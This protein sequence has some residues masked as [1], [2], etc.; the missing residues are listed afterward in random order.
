[1]AN[2]NI[3]V[4]F[5]YHKRTG[6][7]YHSIHHGHHR[8]DWENRPLPFKVYTSLS[9]ILLPKE[10]DPTS[11]TAL[12]AIEADGQATPGAHLPNLPTLARVLFLGNG[13][14]RT[15]R[16]GDQVFS[17]RTSSCTGAL[18]HIELY[19]ACRDLPGLSAGLYHYGAHDHAL[20]RLREGD[21]REI[22]LRATGKEP[23]I[24]HAPVVVI[25][26][27]TFW[28]NSW[29]YQ[30]R[31][32]RHAFWDDGVILANLLAADAAFNLP[33]SVVGG[34]ADDAINELL[35]INTDK[36]VAVSLVAIG[37][38]EA[39]VPPAQR[40]TPLDLPTT[41][42]SPREVDYPL[43]REIHAASSLAEA[44][45]VAW[46][47]KPPSPSVPA[48]TGR[49][50]QLTPSEEGK[51]PVEPL[52]RVILRRGSTR[53]FSPA[54]ISL[55]LLSDM[56]TA[57]SRGVP[58]DFLEPFGASLNDWYL[59]VNGVDGL[60]SGSYFFRREERAL[61]QLRLGDFRSRAGYLDLEQELGQDASVDVYFL[62]D[63]RSILSRF[64]N[65]GYRAAELEAGILGGKLYL[66]A[67]ALGLGATGLTFYDDDVVEFFSPHAAGK[68][69]M[70]L[71]ALGV[72]SKPMRR[73]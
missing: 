69:V 54:S 17:F 5:N 34:F 4:A 49:L 9:P 57:A 44:D 10:S 43:I 8:L 58:A 28:R 11:M 39:P 68:S 16:F 59:I 61:E 7:T 41:A 48:A 51:L 71:M 2:D 12:A 27:D 25:S 40:V 6:H 35:G 56:L 67:Y 30:A 3:D 73:R 62:A 29:K 23:A 19:L 60:P 50:F 21:W 66:A 72:P 46:R 70:F 32:Y 31:E 38:D 26:T 47:G 53:E 64:G 55:T 13:V 37:R 18:Y 15:R 42:L 52:D 33:A 65:R 45:V 1:M 20:R 24:A 63:L 22:I 14:H 36:E